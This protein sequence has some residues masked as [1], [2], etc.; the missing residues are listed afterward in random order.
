[1]IVFYILQ[2][3]ESNNIEVRKRLLHL[4]HVFSLTP[5]CRPDFR[6]QHMMTQLVGLLSDTTMRVAVTEIITELA[7]DSM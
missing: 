4:L 7:A 5:E 3:A 6:A 2:T 1:L